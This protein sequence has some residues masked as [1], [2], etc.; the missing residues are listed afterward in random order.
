MLFYGSLAIVTSALA[1][2]SIKN[3]NKNIRYLA[4]SLTVLIPALFA[5]FRYQIGT[6]YLAYVAVFN[7]I[8]T[9]ISTRMEP[10]YY[11]LNKVTAL[12]G[13]NV[14]VV[15]FLISLIMM[16]FIYLSL[17]NYSKHLSVGLGILVFM[18]TFYQPSFNIVRQITAIAIILYSL[19]YIEQKMF[20]KYLLCILVAASFHLTAIVMLPF[21]FISSV[22]QWENKFYLVIL[23]LLVFIA[24]INYNKILIPIIKILVPPDK[25]YRYMSYMQKHGSVE[26]NLLLAFLKYLP[27]IATS[28]YVILKEKEK[29]RKKLGIY[30]SVFLLGIVLRYTIYFASD[31][32]YRMAYNLLITQVIV[33][34]YVY[35]Q[36]MNENKKIISFGLIAV[37]VFLW[38]HSFVYTGYH[39]T[40]PYQWIF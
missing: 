26:G 4:A 2:L 6:D 27:Y 29:T 39:Q 7:K 19:K 12:L 15:F 16:V 33:I 32:A 20:I 22:L 24:A 23:I 34:P 40:V 8:K 3:R 1:E 18:L 17:K 9:G 35:R 5:G 11:L 28:L 30:F 14:Q 31:Y 38:W 36:F 13:G 21:Y 10:G 25:T 37:V